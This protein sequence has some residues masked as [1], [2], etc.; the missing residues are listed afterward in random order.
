MRDDRRRGPVRIYIIICNGHSP[1]RCTQSAVVAGALYGVADLGRAVGITVFQR[2]NE[3]RL[4][5]T[6]VT[7]HRLAPLLPQ[8]GAN[9]SGIQAPT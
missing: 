5:V 9:R 8:K 4:G 3:N 2:P 7:C 1:R 6:S